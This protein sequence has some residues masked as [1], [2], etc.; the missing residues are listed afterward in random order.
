LTVEGEIVDSTEDE[1]PLEYLHGHKNIIPG[2]EKEMAGMTIGDSKVVN[3]V[4]KDAY[5]EVNPEAKVEVPRSRFSDDIPVEV[6]IQLQVRDQQ[7]KSWMPS[8]R[9]SKAIRLPWI[10]TN[11]WAGPKPE[12]RRQSRRSTPCHRKKTG[13]GHVHSGHDHWDE[14]Y[15][16]RG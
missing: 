13:A 11:P 4:A 16:R 15:R 2:L 1:E 9:R 5:G 14:E 10:S 8:S 7:A 6:G 3:V 12:F